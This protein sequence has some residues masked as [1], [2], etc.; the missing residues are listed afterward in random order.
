MWG[1]DVPG[2]LTSGTYTQLLTQMD[3]HLESLGRDDREAILGQ[4]AIEVYEIV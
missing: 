2:L 1:T 3:V 4:T